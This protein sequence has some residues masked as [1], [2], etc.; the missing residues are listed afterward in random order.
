VYKIKGT[1]SKGLGQSSDWMPEYLPNLYPGTL[2]I[3]LIESMPKISWHTY[4]DTHWNKPIKIADCLINNFPAKIILPPLANT[5]RRPKLVE[6][7]S[8]IKLRD[9]LNLK[10]NDLVEVTF[11]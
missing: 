1:V 2:N 8:E 10:N 9:K 4:I 5:K 3:N 6:I 7:A 11:I